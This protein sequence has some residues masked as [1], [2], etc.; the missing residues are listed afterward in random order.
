MK[1]ADGWEKIWKYSTPEGKTVWH[2]RAYAKEHPEEGLVLASHSP[3]SVKV[4]NPVVARWDSPDTLEEWRAAWEVHLNQALEA[5]GLDVRVDHRSYERQGLNIIPQINESKAVIMEEKR[6]QEEYQRKIDNGEPATL[7]H[8]DIRTQNILIKQHNEGLRIRSE[9]GIL[10]RRMEKLLDPVFI[11]VLEGIRTAAFVIETLRA[12][13]I[14]LRSKVMTAKDTKWETDAKIREYQDYVR[15]MP[16]PDLSVL[17]MQ[18]DSLVQQLEQTKGPFKERL[19]QEISEQLEIV[20]RKISLATENQQIMVDVQ[21]RI[22]KL[23]SISNRVQESMD[24]LEQQIS[25]KMDEYR[26]L[27][28]DSASQDPDEIIGERVRIRP[29]IQEKILGKRMIPDLQ[30]QVERFDQ[31][32]GDV[33]LDKLE[34]PHLSMKMMMT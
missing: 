33:L 3:K 20:E 31:E 21:Q 23:Q 1:M 15:E 11:R 30:R 24:N 14:L 34:A 6:R 17:Q 16:A 9:L 28:S 12:E 4:K 32:M 10:E 19:R 29:E 27:S 8:T 13:I 2:T 18:H 7:V 25:Q 22:E 5:E 26:A